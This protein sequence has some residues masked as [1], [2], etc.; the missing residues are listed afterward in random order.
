VALAAFATSASSSALD[1]PGPKGEPIG[2][3]VTN[4]SVVDYRWDNRN[5]NIN[6][7]NPRPIVDDDYGEWINRLN[8]QATWWRFRLGF[9]IDSAL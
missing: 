8:A 7:F 6:A 2:I 4:T 5:H 1:V 3:D 9:R